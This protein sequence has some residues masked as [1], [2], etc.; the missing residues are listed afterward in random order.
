M[1]GA[2]PLLPLHAIVE[3]DG[4]NFTFFYRNSDLIHLNYTAAVAVLPRVLLLLVVHWKEW[5]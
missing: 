2:T 5:V 4:L 3:M 1:G